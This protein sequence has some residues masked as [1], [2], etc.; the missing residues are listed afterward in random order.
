ML[1][2]L[3]FRAGMHSLSWY[4]RLIFRG[5]SRYDVYQCDGQLLYYYTPV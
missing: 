3:I 1:L 5:L 4:E 2:D